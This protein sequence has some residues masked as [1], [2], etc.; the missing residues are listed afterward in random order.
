MPWVF[1]NHRLPVP[2]K[3]CLI[4]IWEFTEKI[5]G[6]LSVEKVEFIPIEYDFVAEI[7]EYKLLTSIQYTCIQCN[8]IFENAH[9][10]QFHVRSTH[11]L[12][13]RAFFEDRERRVCWKFLFLFLGMRWLRAAVGRKQKK[14]ENVWELQSCDI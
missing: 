5:G 9:N 12:Q 4:E 3:V 11:I 7:W 13:G 1:T 6:G 10:L 14:R 2:S 8:A